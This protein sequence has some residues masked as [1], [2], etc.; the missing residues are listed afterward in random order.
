[1]VRSDNA[2]GDSRVLCDCV[3]FSVRPDNV[4]LFS[5]FW[6]ARRDLA[7][8]PKTEDLLEVVLDDLQKQQTGLS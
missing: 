4:N 8:S 3:L 2:A 6:P 1:M 5:L 7:T